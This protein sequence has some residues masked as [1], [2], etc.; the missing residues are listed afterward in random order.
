MKFLQSRGARVGV[1][2][3]EKSGVS[4]PTFRFEIN[5]KKS[6]APPPAPKEDVQVDEGR[7]WEQH[8]EEGLRKLKPATLVAEDWEDALTAEELL[9]AYNA[10]LQRAQRVQLGNRVEAGIAYSV[11]VDEWENKHIVTQPLGTKG[12][13]VS[14]MVA[15]IDGNILR[16]SLE[17]YDGEFLVL[18]G[19]MGIGLTE[20][21]QNEEEL[22]RI[23]GYGLHITRYHREGQHLIGVEQVRK[24]FDPS[25]GRIV[26]DQQFTLS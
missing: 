11:F 14:E 15:S 12:Q 10:S 7:K 21:Q 13:R 2:G 3:V 1:G 17:R 16:L 5:L 8:V 19:Y 22:T 18:D 4:K 6:K 20:L 24:R 23:P 9:D 25:K 26:S